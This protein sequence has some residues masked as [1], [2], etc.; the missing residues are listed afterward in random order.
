MVNN[1]IIEIIPVIKIKNQKQALNVTDLSYFHVNYI[2]G[3]IRKNKKLSD[4]IIIAKAFTHSQ[5]CYGA[6]S[7]I[8]GFSG[9]SLELLIIHYGS[10]LKF[11]K[12]I[13]GLN[14]NEKIIIDDAKFYR[15]KQDVLKE[16]NEAKILSPIIL[17]DPTFKERNALSGLSNETFLK[18]KKACSE[19]LKNP[20]DE[21]FKKKNILEEMNKKYS[22]LK[23]VSVKT[24]KQKGDIAGTKS[25]KF[26]NFFVHN[27][28]KEFV[29]K[30]IE[31]EYKEN[32]NI[33][34]YYIAVDKKQ[35]ETIR[36]PPITAVENL[37]NFKKVHA[38][39][40]IKEHIAYAHILHNLS[41]EEFLGKFLERNKKVI[42][43]M[44]IEEMK[45]VK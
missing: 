9:Y 6:E 10:F 15:K 45:L 38:N 39:A 31:F 27:L 22:D 21:F 25:K 44:S 34:Y 12:E 16:M 41:F 40:F 4:E 28:K 24:S 26:M 11:I 3:K 33:A 5:N 23:I 32:E 14:E 1:I 18:F 43:D 35:I 42:K 30:K 13:A 17:V 20:S 29:V 37:A 19:F 2:L 7:Y 36:G 8:K